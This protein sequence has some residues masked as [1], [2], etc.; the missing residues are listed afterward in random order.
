MEGEGCEFFR[1]RQILDLIVIELNVFMMI[2]K[3]GA[4]NFEE[5]IFS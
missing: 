1:L 2:E 4:H 5:N 3:I